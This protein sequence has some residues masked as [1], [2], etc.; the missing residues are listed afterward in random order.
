MLQFITSYQE[1]MQM[2]LFDRRNLSIWDQCLRQSAWMKHL[3]IPD[4]SKDIDPLG[5]LSDS[6]FKEHLCYDSK[7]RAS[8]VVFHNITSNYRQTWHP[9]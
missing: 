3:S 7:S 4:G 8:E 1:I 6:L 2:F 5:D 9:H